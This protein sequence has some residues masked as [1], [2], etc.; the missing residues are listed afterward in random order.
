M[1]NIGIFLALA[2]LALVVWFWADSMRAREQALR[3]CAAACRRVNTQLLDETVALR[4]LSV[5]RNAEGRAVWR[6]TYRFEYT[7]DGTQ[8]L[9]GSVIMRGH[10][11]ETMAIQSPDGAT[12]F[13]QDK[14]H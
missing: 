10:Q 6:R 3:V 4:R 9:R 11:V 5:T 7:V 2:V 1:N 14:P 8:R 12:Q 13:E